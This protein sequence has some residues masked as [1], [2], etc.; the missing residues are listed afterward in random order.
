VDLV[1]G[2]LALVSF[3]VARLTESQRSLP[4]AGPSRIST[5]AAAG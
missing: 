5:P 2:G 4:S 1:G 3:S